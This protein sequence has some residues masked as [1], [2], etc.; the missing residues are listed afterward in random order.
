MHKLAV[1]EIVKICRA[2]VNEA[3]VIP[4]SA[5]ILE[6]TIVELANQLDEAKGENPDYKS[7]FTSAVHALA[8][9]DMILGLGSDGCGDPQQTVSAVKDLVAGLR[10]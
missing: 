10:R 3:H 4:F 8:E 9:I 7:M 5:E 2:R 6:N 1:T